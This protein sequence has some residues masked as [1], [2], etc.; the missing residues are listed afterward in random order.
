MQPNAAHLATTPARTLA[1]RL[2]TMADV[3]ARWADQRR[4]TTENR[5]P[6]AHDPDRPTAR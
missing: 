6:E 3:R 2:K 4:V 1:D 5:A